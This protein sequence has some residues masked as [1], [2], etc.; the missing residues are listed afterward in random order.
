LTA[1]SRK[2]L[3]EHH[4]RAYFLL[5]LVIFFYPTP[6]ETEVD[7]LMAK[8][9]AWQAEADRQWA[10]AFVEQEPATAFERTRA[11]FT[12]LLTPLAQKDKENFF[13]TVW[14]GDERLPHITE[15]Q[16]LALMRLT[17]DWGIQNTLLALLGK[18]PQ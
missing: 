10:M 17:Q 1:F 16:G 18:L 4:R 2:P 7:Y 11:W 13:T 3:E 15:M 8:A 5:K 14:Q 12:E 9:S 6:D